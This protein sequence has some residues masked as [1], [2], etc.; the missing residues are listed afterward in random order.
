MSF[1]N[2]RHYTAA[3]SAADDERQVA[4]FH[5]PGWISTR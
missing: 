5:H 4:Q 2:D 3:A 1:G